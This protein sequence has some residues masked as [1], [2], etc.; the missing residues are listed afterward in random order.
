MPFFLKRVGAP[1][2][3]GASH[4][5]I[6]NQ[7]LGCPSSE[8]DGRAGQLPEFLGH[9]HG[10]TSPHTVASGEPG[11]GGTH[12]GFR[13]VRGPRFSSDR[14]QELGVATVLLSS[15]TTFSGLFAG[16]TADIVF[17]WGPKA[18]SWTWEGIVAV[19]SSIIVGVEAA[20]V[21]LEV[22]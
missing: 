8:Q 10:T 16:K 15:A 6:L 1:P 7:L 19:V 22:G 12:L 5:A 14:C 11:G 9:Q 3:L 20:L 17:T 2:S 21:A 18:L 4:P 13:C